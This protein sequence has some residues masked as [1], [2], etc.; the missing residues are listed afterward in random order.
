MKTDAMIL[1]YNFKEDERTRQILRYLNIAGISCKTVSVTDYLHPPGYLFGLPGFSPSH[2]S[3]WAG[4][5]QMRCLS[6]IIFRRNNRQIFWDFS[7]GTGWLRWI[8][9]QCL[10]RLRSTGVR[11]SFMESCR[12]SIRWCTKNDLKKERLYICTVSLFFWIWICV[13]NI[14]G[15]C[16]LVTISTGML[17]IFAT[18]RI[19]SIC[20]PVAAAIWCVGPASLQRFTNSLAPQVKRVLM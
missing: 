18:F 4:I 20:L 3:T 10:H 11:W 8:W 5:L 6:C 12:R 17:K 2:S 7:T 16:Y 9:K 13:S 19:V 14:D 1:M 15:F